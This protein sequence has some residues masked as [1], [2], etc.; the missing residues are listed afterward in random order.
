MSFYTKEEV[1]KDTPH[2]WYT[3]EEVTCCVCNGSTGAY[4]RRYLGLPSMKGN[5]SIGCDLCV[6]QGV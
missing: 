1:E 5:Y 4:Y 2:W 3:Y 6:K